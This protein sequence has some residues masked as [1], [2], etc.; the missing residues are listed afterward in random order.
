MASTLKELYVK[1]SSI[2][3]QI[4]KFKNN[5]NTLGTKATLSSIEITSLSLKITKFESLATKF[6][7]L[8]S[9]TEVLNS[10]NLCL[11]LDERES[12]ECDFITNI[13]TAKE[14]LER[15]TQ[16]D[17]EH[18]RNSV[19]IND[20]QCSLD[21]QDFGIKLP[22]ILISKFDGAYFRWLEFRDT[23]ENLIH[24][25]NRLKNIYKKLLTKKNLLFFEVGKK[26]HYLLSYLEGDAA[27]I[28]SNFEV[29]SDNYEEA[30]K[31][32]C[33]RYNNKRSLINQHLGSLFNI[34]KQNTE[35]EKSLRFLV[36]HVSKILRALTSL[37]QPTDKWDTLIIYLVASKL[38]TDV[39]DSI[40]R[41]KFDGNQKYGQSNLRS[42]TNSQLK[43]ERS[44]YTKSFTT[45]SEHKYSCIICNDG[46]KIYDCP[47]FKS[48][49][50]QER[51]VEVNKHN[52]CMNCLRHGHAVKDCRLGPCKTC[53]KRHNTLLHNPNPTVNNNLGQSEAVVNFSEHLSIQ[54]ILSTAIIKVCNTSTGISQQARA[55]LDC[56]ELGLH[57]TSI[58][59]LKIIGI[60]NSHSNNAAESC[61]VKIQSLCSPYNTK[62]SCLVLNEI[63]S[64]L[65]KA[66]IH[67]QLLKIPKHIQ[68]ADPT[69]DHPAPV[70]VLIGAD[71]FWD[72]LGN[73]ES[74]LSPSGPK[75]RSSKLGWLIS[76]PVNSRY[77]LNNPVHI[78]QIQSN[79]A[80]TNATV[81]DL[82]NSLAKFWE[83]ENIPTKLFL[84]NNEQA[85]EDHFMAQTYRLKTGRFCVKLPLIDS[86]DCLGDTY[87]IAR[88][89]L[90]NLEKKRRGM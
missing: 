64:E 48:K 19:I 53:K 3:G 1:R 87:S 27:R 10:G 12:I 81:N 39:L 23:F 61:T 46:H 65:P 9:E 54:V 59:T 36:G 77:N 47:I 31:I 76:G 63:T 13:A 83:L 86:P 90:I 41:N 30:W 49:N 15:Q 8:Q 51:L 60:G 71:L 16:I 40:H 14:L 24:K 50:I 17:N 66:P 33:E 89:R 72:L 56:G 44:S 82:D 62:L 73:E 26:F 18:R 58:N 25:N 70:D 45:T 29:L 67:K 7:D 35:S 5:L 80:T 2:K 52:L 74:S 75:L 4:T 32:L 38:D 20:T 57:F 28:L 78:N 88:K 37:G 11:E 34:Q 79:H 55:L 68:L 85:C 6:N 84:S 21:H 43:Q 42:N 22:Q 69:F